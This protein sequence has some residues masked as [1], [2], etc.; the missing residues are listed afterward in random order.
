MTAEEREAA[1]K[2]FKLV[3]AAVAILTDEDKRRKYD[4]GAS[5]SHGWGGWGA[6]GGYHQVQE[7]CKGRAVM[8]AL[9]SLVCRQLGCLH[10]PSGVALR[11]CGQSTMLEN[12]QGAVSVFLY[13]GGLHALLQQ[14]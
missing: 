14:E 13:S 6:A 9:G 7:G 3:G 10:R 8:Q 1:E 12:L 4:A 11:M 5:Q 2:K